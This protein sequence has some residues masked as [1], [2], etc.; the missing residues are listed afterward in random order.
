MITKNRS[1]QIALALVMTSACAID[2]SADDEGDVDVSYKLGVNKLGVNKLGVNKLGVNKLGVNKLGVNSLA[3]TDMMANADSREVFSYV[4]GCAIP[5]GQSITAQDAAGVSYVFPGAIGL[6]PSWA[7]RTPTVSERRW[8]TACLLARTNLYGVS[9]QISLRHDTNLA[10]LSTSAERTQ[11]SETEGA[12]Y[13][14]LFATTQTWFACSNRSW[15][16][17]STNSLRMCALSSNG[18]TTDC[19]F[20]YAGPC[21]TACTDATSPYSSCLGG[22][23][24]YPEVITVNLTPT[25]QQGSTQ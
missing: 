5:A 9:V 15:T 13:G 23:T 21:N 19:D 12:F 1:L 2:E 18:T 6:A 24:R 22:S 16:P 20:T 10:L 8:V 25:Q 14:D 3:T 17:Y 7:T 11:Y 4:V